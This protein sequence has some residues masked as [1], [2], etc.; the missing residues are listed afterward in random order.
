MNSAQPN[1]NSP[2]KKPSKPRTN[3]GDTLARQAMRAFDQNK[4]NPVFLALMMAGIFIAFALSET[5]L[6]TD[7][8]TG[9]ATA[10]IWGYGI[11]VFSMLGFILVNADPG[12]DEWSDLIK[13]PWMIILT[14]GILVWTIVLNIKYYKQINDRNVPDEYIM[15]SKYSVYL[16]LCVVGI[17]CY[18]YSVYKSE[19]DGHSGSESLLVYSIIA[20]IFNVIAVSIQQVILSCFY[21]D[22]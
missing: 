9:P 13:L 2:A 14:I 8:S 4:V 6:S 11:V 20:V 5:K 18:Q 22:G 10:L 3:P 19:T 15:W 16:I 7:G 17:T 1:G 12:S 21:V